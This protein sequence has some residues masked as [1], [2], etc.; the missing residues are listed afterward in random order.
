MENKFTLSI[1]SLSAS[2]FSL[3]D[4]HR[5]QPSD[6]SA[7]IL[8]LSPRGDAVEAE[9][10]LIKTAG[11]LFAGSNGFSEEQKPRMEAR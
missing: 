3:D 1:P 8:I 4:I 9:P 6:D 10:A 7:F 5:R 11:Q 2:V